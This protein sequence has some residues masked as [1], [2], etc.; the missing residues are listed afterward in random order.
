MN[1]RLQS[2]ICDQLF[3]I[4]DY[5]VFEQE[6]GSWVPPRAQSAHQMANVA[7]TNLFNIIKSKTLI[8]YRYSNYGFLVHLCQYST[9]SDGQ[10]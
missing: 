8:N 3:V 9:Q 1:K 5:F 6:D 2:T 4:G 10:L 7:A